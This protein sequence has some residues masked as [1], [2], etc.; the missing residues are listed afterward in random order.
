MKPEYIESCADCLV[1]L[2]ESKFGDHRLH[3]KDCRYRLSMTAKNTLTRGDDD[4][5]FI[6]GLISR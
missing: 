4:I 1:E 2:P 3:A 6:S 5:V